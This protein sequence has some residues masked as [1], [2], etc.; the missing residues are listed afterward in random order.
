M[1]A[2]EQR[3]T[4]AESPGRG[5]QHCHTVGAPP[6]TEWA[7]HH[8]NRSISSPVTTPL[9]SH[10]SL[11]CLSPRLS[12][13]RAG[14]GAVPQQT[15]RDGNG[16]RLRSILILTKMMF[17]QSLQAGPCGG[18]GT[19]LVQPSVVGHGGCAHG[20]G[21]GAD[22]VAA[23]TPKTTAMLDLK[24]GHIVIKKP[25]PRLTTAQQQHGPA[26]TLHYIVRSLWTLLTCRSRRR[27]WRC[28]EREVLR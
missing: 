6:S 19:Q 22:S 24:I 3:F 10:L 23:S 5:Q 28:D 15:K 2:P 18:G 8:H 20:T 7:A 1:T 9:F 11:C 16:A 14:V 13:E 12:S 4:I 26:R 25:R 27:H 21:G 17:G